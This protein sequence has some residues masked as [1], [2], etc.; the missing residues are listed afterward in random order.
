MSFR[1]LR[2][3]CCLAGGTMGL[4]YPFLPLLLLDNELDTVAI[5][6]VFGAGALVALVAYPT[7]GLLAD[8]PLGRERSMSL[9]ALVAAVIGV[10]LIAG[11]GDPFVVGACVVLMPFGMASWEPVSDALVLQALGGEA[12]R[13]YGRFRLWMSVGWAATA[14]AGGVLYAVAGP[15]GIL[16]PFVVGSLLIVVVTARP[17]HGRSWRRSGSP[18]ASPRQPLLP[19]LRRALAVAPVLVPLLV[20]TFLEWIV[21]GASGGFTAIL[22]TD[23]GGGAVIIG[24]AAAIPAIIEV[25][26]FPATGWMSERLGLRGLYVLGLLLA[27]AISL[28]IAL[29]QEPVLIALV[30]GLGGVSYVLRYTAVVLIVGAVL[31]HALRATGQSMARFVGGGLAAIVAGPFAGVV[32]GSLGGPALFVICAWL[33]LLGA[34]IAW[35]GLRGP[36]FAPRAGAPPASGAGAP[37]ASGASAA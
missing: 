11:Q 34:A 4:L 16:V 5:G 22:I 33:L 3:L 15:S 21:N 20:A 37:P 28:V 18:G 31:P 29:V 17:R 35:R 30:N 36:A 7:W 13:R 27:G 9:A 6:T 25:P 1:R 19:E 23:L 10:V 12:A 2:V 32:Y 24:L 14:L 26:L 8:G